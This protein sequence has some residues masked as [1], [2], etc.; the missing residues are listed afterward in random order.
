MKAIK[1][2]SMLL[3]IIVCSCEKVEID[4]IQFINDP[5]HPT[6]LDKLKTK[7]EVLQGN[8]ARVDYF[9]NENGF[10]T[11]E[12]TYSG[13]VLSLTHIYERNQDGQKTKEY[14]YESNFAPSSIST[15]YSYEY[16]RSK[17]I[18]VSCF[19]NNE[20][21]WY[22]DHLYEEDLL[23]ES[24]RYEN[25]V[26]VSIN[27]SKYDLSGRVVMSQSLDKEE[28]LLSA[29]WYQYRQDTTLM[30]SSGKEKSYYADSPYYQKIYNT[31]GQ[32]IEEAYTRSVSLDRRVTNRFFYD[33]KHFLR[34]SHHFDAG[35]P[36]SSGPLSIF[37]Y[38]YY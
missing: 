18:K 14:S 1:L 35:F 32:L 8:N 29:I 23:V 10:L 11:K 7:R 36:E 24:K 9:Y 3:L 25:D 2:I 31:R 27:R 38:E 12:E 30:Y 15:Y 13:L 28:N 34:E 21:R 19:R 16:N 22:I 20:L 6:L 5:N 26:L 37:E 17:L 4:N 33:D